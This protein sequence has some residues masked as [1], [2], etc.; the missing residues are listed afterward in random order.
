MENSWTFKLAQLVSWE[1]V[2]RSKMYLHRTLIFLALGLFLASCSHFSSSSDTANL[3]QSIDVS[4]KI[5]TEELAD[6]LDEV[7]KDFRMEYQQFR[8]R[9]ENTLKGYKKAFALVK[10]SLSDDTKE[11]IRKYAE[12]SQEIFST[13]DLDEDRKEAV[14]KRFNQKY[15]KLIPEAVESDYREFQKSSNE[16]PDFTELQSLVVPRG[17]S[18]PLNSSPRFLIGNNEVFMEFSSI[19]ARSPSYYWFNFKTYEITTNEFDENGS[20]LYKLCVKK[21]K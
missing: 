5:A 10:E 2:M 13:K 8:E 9:Q 4:R 19:R 16:A 1:D 11:L 6:I 21:D 3:P 12:G 20:N 17:Y 18:L 15:Q 7:C 14:L